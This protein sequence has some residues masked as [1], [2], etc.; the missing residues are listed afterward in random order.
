MKKRGLTSFFILLLLFVSVASILVLLP[1]AEAVQQTKWHPGHYI[2]AQA[3]GGDQ[4]KRLK[5]IN[6]FI[7]E[8][9]I[10]GASIKMDWKDLE[11]SKGV[12]DFSDIKESLDLVQQHGKYLIVNVIDRNFNSNCNNAP[13][14]SY[15]FTSEY[16]GGWARGKDGRCSAKIW[17]PEVMDRFIALY[18]AL[19]QSFDSEPNFEA[20]Y[21]E[22]TAMNMDNGVEGYSIDKLKIQLKRLIQEGKIMFP[23]TLILFNLNFLG[24]TGQTGIDNLMEFGEEVFQVGGSGLTH[25][26]TVPCR[27]PDLPES[28]ICRSIIPAYIVEQNYKDKVSISPNTQIPQIEYDETQEVFDMAVDTLNADHVMWNS[29]HKDTPVGKIYLFDQVIP[30][31]NNNNGRINTACPTSL[32]T[33]VTDGII[34]PPPS[35]SGA[36]INSDGKV[37]V[38][39]L[40]ILLSNWGASG[41]ADINNDGAVDV[42]D[43]GILLSNWS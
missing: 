22:E 13:I 19:G 39:D 32:G 3:S 35:S 30:T 16:M 15:L 10:L 17:E 31:L 42:T 24:G 28:Q 7:D 33:C 23:N 11:S 37:D 20:V 29:W 12:Y 41:S 4:Q 6:S 40:G 2:R 9:N 43:L 21:N 1:A 36:D 5:S 26:D 18:D 34:S 25:P 27:S 14:P 8:P 38:T